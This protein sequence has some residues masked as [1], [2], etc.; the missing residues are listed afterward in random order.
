MCIFMH[1]TFCTKYEFNKLFLDVYIK[2]FYAANPEKY[3]DVTM[4][5]SKGEGK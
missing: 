1:L 3:S 2:A 5:M 4:Y